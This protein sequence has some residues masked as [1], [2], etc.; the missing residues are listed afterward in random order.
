MRYNIGMNKINLWD[1]RRI[2]DRK[3]RFDNYSI[4]GPYQK[5]LFEKL[6]K[7]EIQ[8]IKDFIL[9]NESI[10]RE[11]FERLLNRFFLHKNRPKNWAIILE[12]LSDIN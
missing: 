9:Q 3:K 4:K 8:L 5:K 6:K 2:E 12:I 10:P 7:N 11:D 1:E